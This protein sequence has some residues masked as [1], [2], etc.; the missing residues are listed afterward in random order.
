MCQKIQS[1]LNNT[2][3]A[4]QPAFFNVDET[5]PQCP[6]LRPSFHIPTWPA[7]AA[8]GMSSVLVVR[9]PFQR[10]ER[11]S[12]MPLTLQERDRRQKDQAAGQQGETSLARVTW[13]LNHYMVQGFLR[14]CRV[15]Y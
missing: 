2:L 11:E 8:S 6:T 15:I 5:R 4:P 3:R 10:N 1:S 12:K 14:F 13:L 9:R 7:H